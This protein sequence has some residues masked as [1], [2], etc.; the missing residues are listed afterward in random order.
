MPEP[1]Y[2]AYYTENT[3]YEDEVKMLRASL[4]K[5]HLPFDIQSIPSLGSWQ[6]NT[7]YKA[8][9]IQNMLFKYPEYPL[10]YVDADAVIKSRPLLFSGLTCDIGVHFYDDQVR[11]EKELLTGTIYVAPTENTKKLIQLWRYINQEYPDRWEQKN[12]AIALQFMPNVAIF[13]LPAA[14]CLIFDLMKG[15]GEAVIEHFQASRRFK[16]IIDDP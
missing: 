14:Y 9:F 8:I 12:L 7:K 6:E 4:E 5:F 11:P 16:E 13:S 15:Q 1:I 2:I 3:P 10:V